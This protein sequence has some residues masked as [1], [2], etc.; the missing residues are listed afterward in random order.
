MHHSQAKFDRVLPALPPIKADELAACH[1]QQRIEQRPVRREQPVQIRGILPVKPLKSAGQALGGCKFPYKYGIELGRRI[2]MA[3]F[4]FLR[5][6]FIHMVE[7]CFV[8]AEQPYPTEA[9]KFRSPRQTDS[10]EARPSQEFSY[11]TK[12][13]RLPDLSRISVYSE[14]QKPEKD[15]GQ[16]NR[17]TCSGRV[18][19][20]S[21]AP[22]A[23]PPILLVPFRAHC[24]DSAADSLSGS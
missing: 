18:I 21:D 3:A 6:D 16:H 2:V 11:T 5:N 8:R 9:R 7:R 19:D 12:N 13:R 10:P 17:Q 22:L 24:E 14:K 23:N 20:R 15:D 1:R 4:R